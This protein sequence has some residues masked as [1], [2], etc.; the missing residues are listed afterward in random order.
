MAPQVP[1][2]L[3]NQGHSIVLSVRSCISEFCLSSKHN[4]KRIENL[5]KMQVFLLQLLQNERKVYEI[6]KT[7]QL[8]QYVSYDY[9]FLGSFLDF[10][11]K[12]Y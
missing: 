9:T 12:N 2:A 11:K 5:L 10:S 3:T 6:A 1:R 7:I 8:H 4:I